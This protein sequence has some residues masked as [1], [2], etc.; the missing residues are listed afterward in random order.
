MTETLGKDPANIWRD[1]IGPRHLKRAQV[2]KIHEASLEIMD[3]TG[4]VVAH[5]L[6]L[7]CIAGA[8]GRGEGVGSAVVI[9]VADK[10][11]DQVI[12]DGEHLQVVLFQDI[13]LLLAVALVGG[14]EGDI[15]MITPAGQLQAIVAPIRGLFGEYFQGQ[16][17]PLS[18]E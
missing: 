2:G 1:V 11:P 17:S 12:A 14:G 7:F 16:I 8:L 10:L 4:V 6:A 3:R 15:E 9:E 13:A 5:E 18:G